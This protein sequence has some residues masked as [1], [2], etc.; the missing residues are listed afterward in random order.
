MPGH[1]APRIGELRRQGVFGGAECAHTK[2]KKE[3]SP[4]AIVGTECLQ[5]LPTAETRGTRHFEPPGVQQQAAGL[6][7][8]R[9]TQSFPG[10]AVLGL[11]EA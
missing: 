10:N 4:T 2:R 3:R 8:S 7:E 1:W 9:A 11:A 6:S 5:L